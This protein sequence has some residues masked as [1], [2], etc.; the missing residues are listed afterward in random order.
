[1]VDRLT[2][3]DGSGAGRVVADHAAQVGPA[4]GRH[5]GS[6]LQ[7]MDSD[8]PVQLVQDHTR[9]HP[10]RPRRRIDIEDAVEIL[11][12]VENKARANRLPGKAGAASSCR[13]R[14]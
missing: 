10:Y 6:E 5:F 3:D 1:M 11:A 9:L 2:V 4:G 14:Y 8:G 13:D 12:A 7:T